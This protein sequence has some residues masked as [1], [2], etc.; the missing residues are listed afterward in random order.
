[1]IPGIQLVMMVF[2]RMVQR[3]VLVN[4]ALL[5]CLV[6]QVDLKFKF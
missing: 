6:Y 4:L 1:V 2:D 5:V 3:E